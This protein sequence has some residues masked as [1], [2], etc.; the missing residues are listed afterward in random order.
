ML[1]RNSKRSGT[2]KGKGVKH[3][4]DKKGYAGKIQNCGAQK[5]QAPFASTSKRG[6]SIVKTGNDL[7]TGKT[8]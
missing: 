3:M 5:V 8:K 6:N 4:A 7:R 1:P 2:T